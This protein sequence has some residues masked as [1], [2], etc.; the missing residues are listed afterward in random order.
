[1]IRHAQGGCDLPSSVHFYGMPLSVGYGEEE[2]IVTLLLGNRC[3]DCG[4][5]S[6][7]RQDDCSMTHWLHQIYSRTRRRVSR[8]VTEREPCLIRAE[9]GYSCRDADYVREEL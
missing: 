8:V 3:R 9:P 2:E 1:M 7:T 5:Q 4:I 6:S